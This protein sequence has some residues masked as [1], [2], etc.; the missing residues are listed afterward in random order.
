MHQGTNACLTAQATGKYRNQSPAALIHATPPAPPVSAPLSA[1]L[2]E[3]RQSNQVVRR[4]PKAARHAAAEAFLTKLSDCIDGQGEG[5]WSRLLQFFYAAFSLPA[6]KEERKESLSSLVKR[7]LARTTAFLTTREKNKPVS[8]SSTLKLQKAVLRKM[9]DGDVSGAVR[10]LT[11]VDAI[12]APTANILGSLRTK[13]PA[14]NP[15]TIFPDPPSAADPKPPDVTSGEV[16]E[17]IKS[18][19]NGSAGGFDGLLPQHLKDMTSGAVGDLQGAPP[20][21]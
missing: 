18:F 15:D 11:S 1:S 8:A 9:N 4:I 20:T 14:A 19:P 6:T 2:R 10:V 12:A 7:Y 16:E 5:A 17:A 13:H 3:L 21:L